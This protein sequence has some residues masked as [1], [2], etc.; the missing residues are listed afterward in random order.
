LETKQDQVIVS[1]SKMPPPPPPAPPPPPLPPATSGGANIEDAAGALFA[2]IS[3]L[4]EGGLRS[5]LKK[6]TRGPVNE[7]VPDAAT[8]PAAPVATK[9]A[10]PLTGIPTIELVGKKWTVENQDGNRDININ[11][12]MKQTLYIYKC[13]DSTVK[14]NGK[15]NAIVLDSCSKTACVFEEAMATIEIVNSK[16]I[17]VQCLQTAPAM[18]IDGCT[19]VTYYMSKTFA[20]CQIIT[21]KCAAINLIRP[22]DDDDV[23]QSSLFNGAILFNR[24]RC[25]IL[26]IRS[27]LSQ[28]LLAVSY[29]LYRLWRRRFRNSF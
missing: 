19:A 8:M 20:S 5:A 29:L 16:D 1:S 9:S 6:A 24:F 21:A 4:G 13:R 18:S 26:T 23:R 27:Y 14:V 10:A 17:Q 7:T 25:N 3:K 22:T 12:T 15:I 11:A 28:Y 2:E